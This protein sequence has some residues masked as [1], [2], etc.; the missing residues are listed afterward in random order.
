MPPAGGC[1]AYQPGGDAKLSEGAASCTGCW[2]L[3]AL[4][5]FFRVAAVILEKTSDD[6]RRFRSLT[7]VVPSTSPPY[8]YP[9]LSLCKGDAGKGGQ[10]E[11]GDAQDADNPP[12][13]FSTVARGKE[14]FDVCRLFLASLQLVSFFT[15]ASFSMGSV[16]FGSVLDR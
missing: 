3:G 1:L 8:V 13:D 12:V 9:T 10:H 2:V 6:A 15:C 7:N 14:P 16:R 11:K 5:Y 4:P